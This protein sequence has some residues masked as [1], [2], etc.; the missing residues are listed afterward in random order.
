MTV[1]I[2]N[3]PPNVRYRNSSSF[4]TG[5]TLFSWFLEIRQKEPIS[6]FGGFLKTEKVLKRSI[7]MFENSAPK[8]FS[9]T[10]MKKFDISFGGK[11]S[12]FTVTPS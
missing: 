10:Y 1:N 11:L 3:S 5:E 9:K 12:I 4:W 6:H 7:V 2:E 8:G